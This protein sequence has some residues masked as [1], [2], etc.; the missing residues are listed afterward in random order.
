MSEPRLVAS[1]WVAALVRRAAAEGLFATVLRRG[2]PVAGAVAVVLRP[3]SGP[4]RVL[5]RVAGPE[6][7]RWAD[8][9]RD[10]DDAA[11]DAW[12]QRQA[13]YDPD[14]WV[15]ELLGEDAQRLVVDPRRD[16]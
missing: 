1:V 5:A 10:A 16:D 3:R 9:L 8:A 6:G 15:V 2:D 12:L 4:V 14:L 7:S 11:L 13:R